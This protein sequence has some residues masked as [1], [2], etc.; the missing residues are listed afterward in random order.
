[1]F[2]HKNILVGARFIRKKTVIRKH[3]L[4]LVLDGFLPVTVNNFLNKEFREV[5]IP[6]QQM[7]G[8]NFNSPTIFIQSQ[9]A[10]LVRV[11]VV[12][13]GGS[14]VPYVLYVSQFATESI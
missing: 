4:Q 7:C 9:L 10:G 6:K 3:Y 1:M 11:Q 13:D 2:V 12:L 14:S 5:L 8:C